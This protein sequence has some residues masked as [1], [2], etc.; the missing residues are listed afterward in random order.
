MSR[1][2]LRSTLIA[3]VVIAS[4]QIAAFG[5]DGLQPV[6]QSS[7]ASASVSLSS[8]GVEYASPAAGP[9]GRPYGQPDL[10]YNFYVPA[11]CDG[12]G[13]SLYLAPRP[14]PPH[15][16]YTYY[17]YQPLMPH[18]MLY[19]HSRNYHRYYHGG[20][21]LTRTKVTWW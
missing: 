19:G 15:V 6:P 1:I 5:A 11:V 14:V 17:T 12:V 10:F 20:R 13:A 2:L 7:T 18:E 8:G 21:G 4:G 3:A 16:G 9:C